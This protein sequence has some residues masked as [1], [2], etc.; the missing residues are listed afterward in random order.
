MIRDSSELYTKLVNDKINDK[1]A[2]YGK[3]N[4]FKYIFNPRGNNGFMYGDST[5]N[6]THQVLEYINKK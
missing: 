3:E 5:L 2:Q 6:V 1:V 4:G